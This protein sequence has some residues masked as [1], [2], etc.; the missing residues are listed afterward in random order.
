MGRPGSF[1]NWRV[2]VYPESLK[3]NWLQILKNT[4]IEFSVSPLHCYDYWTEEDEHFDPDKNVVGELKKP[5]YHL[6]LHFGGQKS[7]KSVRAI[8]RTLVP[9]DVSCPNVIPA[10]DIGKAVRYLCHYDE[11]STKHKYDKAAI[12]GYNGFDVEKY[13]KLTREQECD[14]TSDIRHFIRNMKI[15]EYAQLLDQLGD[16]DPESPVYSDYHDMY[17]YCLKHTIMINSYLRSY[18]FMNMPKKTEIKSDLPFDD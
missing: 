18:K 15:F 14:L 2:I 13:F 16:V 10:Y 17:L 1:C 11:D 6:V 7:V 4:L 3:E 12:K 9:D 5:H 8:L